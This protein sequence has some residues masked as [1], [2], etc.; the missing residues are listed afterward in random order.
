MLANTLF[1]GAETIEKDEKEAVKWYKIL[2]ENNEGFSQLMLG[3]IYYGCPETV[4]TD[5]E[6]SFQYLTLASKNKDIDAEFK[7]EAKKLLTK[8]F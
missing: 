5:L 3:K 7:Q 2:A 6:K 4:E 8:L 1:T